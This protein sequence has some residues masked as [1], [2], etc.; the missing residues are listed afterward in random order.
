MTRRSGWV[1][2][3][4]LWALFIAAHIL[5]AWLGWV[6]P[7]APR[8]DV[9][10]VYEP[11]SA[12]AIR[13][14]GIVGVTEPWV[15]PPLALMP[16]I[17]AQLFTPLL[18]Y[19]WAWIF[20]VF[21]FDAAAFYL[22]VG[23]G[24]SRSRRAAAIFWI[25]FLVA[26]G[27]IAL[28][29]LDAVTVPFAVAGVLLIRSHPV[30]ASSLLAMAAWMKIWTGAILAAA[31]AALNSKRRIVEGTL[32]VSAVVVGIVALGGGISFL[33]GFLSMQSSRGLQAEAV[34][35]TPFLWSAIAGVDGAGIEY[36]YD[37]IT[38]QVAGNGVAFLADILTPL[39][40]IAAVALAALGLIA[41]QRGV[42]ARELM[43]PLAMAAVLAF[44]V[45]NKVG[46]PQFQTWLI[47]PVVLWL[48][49][50]RRRALPYAVSAVI[51]AACTHL[52]YPLF[53]DL[54]LQTDVVVVTIITIRNL[55]LVV[56]MLA[57]TARVAKLAIRHPVPI[58]TL[59]QVSS[60]APPNP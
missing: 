17:L 13:G 38:F 43:P 50:D 6:E 4:A 55:L 57:A 33:F 46:S 12:Y 9:T 7:N 21:L 49:W 59:A 54:F 22:L 37:L 34:F 40:L 45:F 41:H 29:R 11:W 3:A 8:N 35:A 36:D 42:S 28:Y 52:I 48:L 60:D 32:V 15:Y 58:T 5:V 39:L 51:I 44:I 53:Y 30:L 19:Q 24:R 56:L 1:W 2:A 16:M 47:A 27:P 20:V 23:G 26:L 10:N 25:V 31:F 18:G 14:Q